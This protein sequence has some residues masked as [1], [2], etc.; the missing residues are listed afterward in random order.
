MILLLQAAGIASAMAV[1]L[2]TDIC[3]IDV[4]ELQKTLEEQNVMIHFD[5]KLIPQQEQ[6]DT[7]AHV[8]GHF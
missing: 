5:N 6:E 2:R 4:A 7:V 8:D 1:D 3:K